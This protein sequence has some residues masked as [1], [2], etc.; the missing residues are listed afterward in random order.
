MADNFCDVIAS[1]QLILATPTL[2]KKYPQ[3]HLYPLSHT[4]N[5]NKLKCVDL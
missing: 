4:H 3:L 5:N 1:M 2:I